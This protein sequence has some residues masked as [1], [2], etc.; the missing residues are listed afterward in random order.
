M[1]GRQ[2]FH[3]SEVQATLDTDYSIRRS[4]GIAFGAGAPTVR[5]GGYQQLFLARR[6]LGLLS[7]KSILHVKGFIAVWTFDLHWN[8]PYRE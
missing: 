5:C 3:G 7:C 4:V 2:L 8:R 1:A 6:A